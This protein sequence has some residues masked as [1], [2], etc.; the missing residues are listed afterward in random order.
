MGLCFF[1]LSVMVLGWSHARFWDVFV[2][3]EFCELPCVT[4]TFMVKPTG[5]IFDDS[6][7]DLVN[8]YIYKEPDE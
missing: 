5:P 6:L 7:V 2:D 1:A 8:V 3:L 4:C